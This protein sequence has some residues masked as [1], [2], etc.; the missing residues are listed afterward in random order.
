MITEPI[1]PYGT[2]EMNII[3][4]PT[5]NVVTKIEIIVA[6]VSSRAVL[7]SIILL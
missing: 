6:N 4:R 2:L 1:H 3:D 7:N 5:N